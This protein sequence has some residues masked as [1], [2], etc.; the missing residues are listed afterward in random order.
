MGTHECLPQTQVASAACS[1]SLCSLCSRLQKT[2]CQITEIYVTQ[3]DVARIQAATG[4]RDFHEFR[5]PENPDY[6]DQDDDPVWAHFVFRADQSRRILKHKDDGDC[7]FLSVF[8]CRLPLETRP[9]VC[10]IYPYDYSNGRLTGLVQGLCPVTLLEPGQ[11]LT[12]ALGM[13]QTEQPSRWIADLYKEIL[14]E[15]PEGPAE[16]TL[17]LA[18]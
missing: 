12:V 4:E 15:R 17:P 13:E 14:A 8:G 2:C 18:A 1:F 11:S 16:P 9:L 10:R 7:H 3:A 5:V 6:L